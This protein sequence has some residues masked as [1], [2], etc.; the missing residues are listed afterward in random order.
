MQLPTFASGFLALAALSHAAQLTQVT[1]FGANP[2][3]ARMFL[4]VPD[5]VAANPPIVVAIHYA[6]PPHPLFHHPL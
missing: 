2:S 6:S 5:K 4:Y 3:G 1:N